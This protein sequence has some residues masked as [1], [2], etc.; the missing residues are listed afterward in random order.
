MGE[1]AHDLEQVIRLIHGKAMLEPC[2]SETYAD[3]VFNLHT[4]YAEFPALEEG[5][6]T[7]TFRHVL[8]NACQAE[9]ERL[10]QTLKFS[11]EEAGSMSLDEMAH[12]MTKRKDRILANMRFIGHL[13]LRDLLAMKVISSVLHDLI[14][15]QTGQDGWP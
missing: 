8:L 2:Y 7:L 12:Q 13:F 14:G 11:A 6:P 4:C 10:P 15:P 3:M 9:F 1:S 5:G